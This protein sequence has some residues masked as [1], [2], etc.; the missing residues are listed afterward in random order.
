MAETNRAAGGC[1]DWAC[2]RERT[3]HRG[4]LAGA[5]GWNP[6]HAGSPPTVAPPVMC[7]VALPPSPRRSFAWGLITSQ[8]AWCGGLERP[9]SIRPATEHPVRTSHVSPDRRCP[10]LR[11]I[12]LPKRTRHDGLLWFHYHPLHPNPRR[13]AA[14]GRNVRI[15]KAVSNLSTHPRIR[16]VSD[17]RGGSRDASGGLDGTEFTLSHDPSPTCRRGGR[18]VVRTTPVAEEHVCTTPPPRAGLVTA[19]WCEGRSHSRVIG[20][21]FPPG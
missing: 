12:R 5:P 19:G 11:T 6:E 1:W 20:C 4:S 18:R 10:G 17:V 2:E 21:P 16:P 7:G 3:Q 15:W 8:P 9:G 14:Q 13:M